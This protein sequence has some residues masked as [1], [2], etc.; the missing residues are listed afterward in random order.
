M[1]KQNVFEK[2]MKKAVLSY[3]LGKS[4]LNGDVTVIS[5]FTIDSFSRRVDLVVINNGRMVAY[6]IKSDADSLFRLHG[7]LDKYLKYFDKVVVVSASRHIKKILPT[8]SG[9]VEVW[10]VNGDNIVIKKRGRVED[11]SFKENYLD[12]LKV[13]DM[14][15][16]AKVMKIPT[17][18]TKDKIKNH[19][20]KNISNIN[21]AQLKSFILE[22]ISKRFYLTSSAFLEN[23]KVNKNITLDDL[24]LLSPYTLSRKNHHLFEDSI[25]EK[26]R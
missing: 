2:E 24:N 10:E 17:G 16:L 22:S 7:Q 6:E 19:L 15:R 4:K 1:S 14:K 13:V 21:H 20:L 23:I 26:S 8:V 12:L 18:G 25:I 11:I 9:N 5:E 3:L